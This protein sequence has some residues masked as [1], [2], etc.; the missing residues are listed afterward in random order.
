MAW[1]SI[2]GSTGRW[3]WLLC[4]WLRGDC[5]ISFLTA[6][7]MQMKMKTM[8][9]TR[10]MV[11]WVP[12]KMLSLLAL[13][14]LSLVVLSSNIVFGKKRLFLTHKLQN[15]HLIEITAD[16]EEM[17]KICPLITMIRGEVAIASVLIALVLPSSNSATSLRFLLVLGQAF[18][19]GRLV[20]PGSQNNT[21]H[22]NLMALFLLPKNWNTKISK[23]HLSCNRLTMVVVFSTAHLKRG[24]NYTKLWLEHL[25]RAIWH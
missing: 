24:I 1:F 10:M 21:E 20:S 5:C 19:Q 6:S 12:P 3:I 15:V 7:A 18:V 22:S 14:W 11:P 17:K 13:R 9:N 8:T 16:N 25:Q 4:C 2:P 23:W